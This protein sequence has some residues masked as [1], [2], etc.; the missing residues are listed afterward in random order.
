MGFGKDFGRGFRFGFEHPFTAIS[1]LFTGKTDEKMKKYYGDFGSYL[2]KGI[3]HYG[4]G[5]FGK[6]W[7][8]AF[9]DVY[10]DGGRWG[11]GRGVP[12][13]FP[14][15]FGDTGAAY[16]QP[17]T[18]RIIGQRQAQSPNYPYVLA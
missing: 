7:A 6:A 18:R 17:T 3:G 12:T 16:L 4:D 14:A 10:G 11:G 8:G 9:H 1:S 5:G 15:G 13:N 2:L